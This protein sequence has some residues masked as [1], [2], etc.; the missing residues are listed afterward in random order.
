[1]GNRNSGLNLLFH[2]S[3]SLSLTHTHT[4]TC[5]RLPGKFLFS[6]GHSWCVETFALEC[7]PSSSQGP[8]PVLVCTPVPVPSSTGLSLGAETLPVVDHN[9][10]VGSG[11]HTGACVGS[12]QREPG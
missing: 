10:P 6:V 7:L 1:M 11:G 3:L 12:G 4:H 5:T 8:L 2:L 9:M